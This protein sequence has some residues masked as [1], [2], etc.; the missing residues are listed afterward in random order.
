MAPPSEYGLSFEHL[1][2]KWKSKYKVW[3][4]LWRPE[5][6]PGIEKYALNGNADSKIRIPRSL[7]TMQMDFQFTIN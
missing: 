2:L 4:I 3:S 1:N 5:I 7:L 6:K